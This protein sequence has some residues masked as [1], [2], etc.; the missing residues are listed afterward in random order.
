MPSK[1]ANEMHRRHYNVYEAGRF[2][3]IVDFAHA[4]AILKSALK[5][6]ACNNDDMMTMK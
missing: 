1:M 4:D 2:V 3:C 5:P 6:H